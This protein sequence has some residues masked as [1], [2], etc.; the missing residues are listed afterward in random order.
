MPQAGTALPFRFTV[1]ARVRL[2][3]PSLFSHALSVRLAWLTGC[4]QFGAQNSAKTPTPAVRSTSSI[5]VVLEVFVA[6]QTTFQP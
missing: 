5:S 3:K 4:A 2:T 1:A 6:L